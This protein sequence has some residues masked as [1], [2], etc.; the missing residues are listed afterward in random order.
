[1]SDPID[2]EYRATVRRIM[3]TAVVSSL[4]MI[5]GA[6]VFAGWRFAGAIACSAILVVMNFVWLQEIV[7]DTLRSSPDISPASVGGRVVFRMILM[8][9][10]VF[11]TVAV[12]RFEPVGVAL[13]FSVIVVGIFGEAARA[14]GISLRGD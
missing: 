4:V 5:A 7:Q 6:V 1:M 13:G 11:A 9:V 3:T 12:A 14:I 10:S 8:T 2:P